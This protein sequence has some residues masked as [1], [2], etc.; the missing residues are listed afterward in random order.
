MNNTKFLK[1]VIMLLL[2]IN[3]ITIAFMWFNRPQPKDNIGD[4]FAK[5][6]HFTEKQ[7][8]EYKALREEHR[9]QRKSLRAKNKEKH[10]AFF[11]LLKK[12]TVDSVTI[13]K[14]VTEL[15]I[16]REKEELGTFSHFQKVRAICDETQKEK[17]DKIINEA[18]RMMTPKGPRGVQEPPRREDGPPPPRP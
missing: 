18:A 17:F 9:E 3:I 10:D 1:V 12:S 13:K 7:K 2:L 5:E 15:L 11:D 8:E 14:A 6:L 4:F 16:I